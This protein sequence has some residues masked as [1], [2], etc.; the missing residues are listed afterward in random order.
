[1][2]PPIGCEGSN[3]ELVEEDAVTPLV[4]GR[5][6][7]CLRLLDAKGPTYVE[8]NGVTPLAEGHVMSCLRSLDVRDPTKNLGK[9][10]V[11]HH[12]LEDMLCHASAYWM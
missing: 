6:V 9:M 1:M 3:K 7:S 12:W 5:V 8:G 11:S 10:T 2:P 4:G